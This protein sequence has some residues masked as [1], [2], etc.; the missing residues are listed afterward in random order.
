M[1]S[2]NVLAGAPNKDSGHLT[3]EVATGRI[4]SLKYDYD[5]FGNRRR[6]R[7]DTTNQSNQSSGR[8]VIDN[9][10]KYDQEGRVLVADGFVNDSGNVV[11]GKLGGKA[12]GIAMTYGG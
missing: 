10:Y 1:P 6:V 12:K 8:T 4:D 3:L 5:E 9:W 2:G 11:A 7:L